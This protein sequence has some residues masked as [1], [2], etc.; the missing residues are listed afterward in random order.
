[1]KFINY[2]VALLLIA[3]VFLPSICFYPASASTTTTGTSAQDIPYFGVTFGGNTTAEAKVLIDKVKDYTNLFVIANWDVAMN[4]SALTEICQYAY[5]ANLYFMVYF[6]FVFFNGSQLNPNWLNLF[7]EAGVEPF[8]Y[9]WLSS[10]N[11]K[12]GDKFLGAYVLD[13]PGG[14]Q[15]DVGNYN[16][17]KTTFSG[18][19]QTTFVNASGYSDAATRFVRG[20]SR[21]YVQRLNNAS[22]PNSIPNSTGR[23]IPVFT[24]DNALYWF[25][26]LA[27]YNAVFGELGWTNNEVQHIALCRG[28]ADVQNKQWGAMIA[29]ASNDPPYL[30][31]GDKMFQQLNLAYSAGAQYL[32]VFN[33]PQINPYGALEDQHFQALQKFWNQ[34]HNSPRTTHKNW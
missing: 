17:F 27:G 20:L 23:V 28:A 34:I 19:N 26:Y 18:A 14:K 13:E 9:A 7:K 33:Y 31:T 1:M 15:I 11:D 21:Y 16:G 32:I 12:W 4:E 5:D 2:P 10:A 25:D 3:V 6:S 8:H 24:A 22:Y 29:W 30:A